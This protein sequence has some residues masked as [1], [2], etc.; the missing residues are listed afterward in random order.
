MDKDDHYL[1]SMERLDAK[2]LLTH[3]V[4][5]GASE[6]QQVTLCQ[7][8]ISPRERAIMVPFCGQSNTSNQ[9]SILIAGGHG[10]DG[11]LA[12]GYILEDTTTTSEPN[13]NAPQ[14]TT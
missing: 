6:W 1:A 13:I 4:N 12:D 10:Y 8:V 3:V 7:A 2:K 14:Q 9:R 5:C 11:Y